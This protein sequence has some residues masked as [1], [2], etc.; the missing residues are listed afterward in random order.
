MRISCVHNFQ[1]QRRG[2]VREREKSG[3]KDRP[4]ALQST[5]DR[6][7]GREGDA[8]SCARSAE[9]SAQVWCCPHHSISEGQECGQNPQ[10]G[11]E[12]QKDPLWTESLG[13]PMS[14]EHRWLGRKMDSRIYPTSGKAPKGYPDEDNWNLIEG[15]LL[16]ALLIHLFLGSVDYL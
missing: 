4:G 6:S 3:R 5:W 11:T 16:W 7:V 9:R 10:K 1:I 12:N 15:P 8:G 2:V 14:C 13:M